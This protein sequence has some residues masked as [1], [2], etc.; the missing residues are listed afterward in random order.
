MLARTQ[1]HSDSVLYTIRLHAVCAHQQTHPD[2]ALLISMQIHVQ[3]H[4]HSA[5]APLS[6]SG[7]H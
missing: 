6:H 3:A 1:T 7:S 4:T 5:Q 2:D